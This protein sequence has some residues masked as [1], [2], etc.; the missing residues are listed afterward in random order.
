[1]YRLLWVDTTQVYAELYADNALS[2][3]EETHEQ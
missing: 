2:T 3:R 1:M